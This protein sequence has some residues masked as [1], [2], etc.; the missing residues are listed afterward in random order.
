MLA[1]A[2][3]KLPSQ[4]KQE[5]GS[6]DIEEYQW[7][8]IHRQYFTM[9]PF[10]EVPLLNKIWNRGY[11][12]GGN[13][14]T[15]NVAIYV[16]AAKKYNAF[17]SPAFRFITDMNKTYYSLETGQSDRIFTSAFFDN[18]LDK[19]MYLEYV[20]IN[21]YKEGLPATWHFSIEKLA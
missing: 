15:L 7:G 18:F 13:S 6:S 20:P 1:L 14:R 4:L 5:F 8:K 12:A 2:F 3:K 17:A 16:H 19:N 10:S 11:P 9:I 21:P